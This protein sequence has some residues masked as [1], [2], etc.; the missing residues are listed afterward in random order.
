MAKKDAGARVTVIVPA[1]M[2]AWLEQL[3]ADNWTSLSHEIVQALRVRMEAEQRSAVG[4]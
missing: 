3:A 4:S 1:A 2:K